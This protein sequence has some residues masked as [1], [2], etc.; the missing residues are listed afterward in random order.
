MDLCCR[1]CT[2]WHRQSRK[3]PALHNWQRS[4]PSSPSAP[5]SLHSTLLFKTT[6]VL[7]A[8]LGDRNLCSFEAEFTNNML[9]LGLQRAKLLWDRAAGCAASNDTQS[10][11]KCSQLSRF[12]VKECASIVTSC[13]LSFL[14]TSR[15]RAPFDVR[16]NAQS[17]VSSGATSVRQRNK[18]TARHT[19]QPFASR[20]NPFSTRHR[21]RPERC[22]SGRL[23]VSTLHLLRCSS[24]LSFRLTFIVS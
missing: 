11:W 8:A 23:H 20:A 24:S 12:F 13:S 3:P 1:T 17:N 16:P 5:S 15:P 14:F 10:A 19:R 9:A 21:R 4:G 7:H 2:E 18:S 6:P 22:C